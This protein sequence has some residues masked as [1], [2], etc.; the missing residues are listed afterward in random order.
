MSAS[1]HS[2]LR[3]QIAETEA[4]IAAGN[5][6]LHTL[7]TRLG[8]AARQ[9]VMAKRRT[10]LWGGGAIVLVAL[11]LYPRRG[12][13]LTRAH[14]LLSH[15]MGKLLLGGIPGASLLAGVLPLITGAAAGPGGLS[16]LGRLGVRQI[17]QQLLA[18][19][20]RPRA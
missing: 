6:R 20:T 7:R 3:E 9:V 11:V 19:V 10:W 5:V 8:D 12:A 2:S 1:S 14:T 16:G 15:P 13:L 17:L 4:A 18:R